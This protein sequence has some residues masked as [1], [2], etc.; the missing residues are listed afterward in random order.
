[1]R[2]VYLGPNDDEGCPVCS[3]PLVVTMSA[4]KVETKRPTPSPLIPADEDLRLAAV[5]RYD[6]LDSPPDGAFDRITDLAARIFDVPI[7]TITIVDRDRIWFKAKHGLDAESI[8]RDSG[9]C[10]SAILEGAPWVVTDAAVDPRTLENPL[11]RGD[12][13]LRFYAGAQL[14]TADGHNLGTLNIID[15]HPREMSDDEMHMLE[16]L[17][18]VVMDELEL[19]L[20]ALRLYRKAA[21]EGLSLNQ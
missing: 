10:A 19:R 14:H 5:N 9:L 16:Q 15:T 13:G 12:L 8:G 2:T 3:S 4:V 20:S 18:A 11:V 21:N 6:I 7:S 17:A 1:M